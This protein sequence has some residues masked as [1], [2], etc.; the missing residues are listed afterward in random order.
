MKPTTSPWFIAV[1]C[2]LLCAFVIG[3]MI[4]D[5][6]PASSTPASAP[7][8]PTLAAGDENWWMG[9][10]YPGI[11]G[12]PTAS[13]VV[14]LAMTS[15][16]ALY[17]GVQ[18]SSYCED[19]AFRWDSRTWSPFRPNG[20]PFYTN[21]MIVDSEDHIYFSTSGHVKYWDGSTLQTLGGEFYNSIYSLALDSQGNLY[22]GGYF[23]Q[24]GGQPV[25]NNIARWD[26]SAWQP[27]GLGTDGGV[28]SLA[29]DSN[30]NLYA[31]GYFTQAGGDTAYYLARWDGENWW[32]V[33][34]GVSGGYVDELII[35]PAT[36]DLIVGGSFTAPAVGVARWDGASWHAYGT[37]KPNVADL[38][39]DPA[40]NLYAV[41]NNMGAP[42][43]SRW[44]G[45]WTNLA[46]GM[47]GLPS[48]V[49]YQD[50]MLYV[51]GYFTTLA[52]I[53]VYRV[54]R[55]DGS[56]W[57]GLG[58]GTDYQVNALAYNAE[59]DLIAGGNFTN[60]GAV[61]A[62]GAARWD[63][64]LWH[65]LGSGIEGDVNAL[66][67][68]PAGNLIA[69]GLFPTAGGVTMN[70]ISR[71]NGSIWQALG[72]GL[73]GG[74]VYAVAADASNIYAGGSFT[75]AGGAAADYIARWDGAAWQALGSG[76]NSQVR[77]L[78][79]HPL[80]G[81]LYAAGWFSQAGGSPA[82]KVA[83][84]DGVAWQALSSDTINGNVLALAFDPAG[85]LYIGGEF[86][87]AGGVTV[88]RIA[89][90]NGSAWLALGSGAGGA[91]RSLAFSPSGS[92][93]VGGDF[94]TIGGVAASRLAEWDG[95]AWHAF[96]SGVDNSVRALAIDAPG[97][98]FVGGD[99]QNAGGISSRYIAWYAHPFAVSGTVQNSLGDPVPGI[100]ISSFEYS[101]DTNASGV[102]TL[103]LPAWD[104]TLTPSKAYCDLCAFVPISRTVSIT[105]TNWSR[106]DFVIDPIYYA[107][108]GTV[109]DHLGLPT[110]G[111]TVTMGAET[112]LSDADGVYRLRH[113]T[114]GDY[115]LSFAKPD[116][117]FTP[118]TL[119]TTI[120][121]QDVGLPVVS[122]IRPGYQVV[123]G[124]FI[125]PWSGQ[126]TI[127]VLYL[128]PA[129]EIYFANP[130]TD[131]YRW[132]G[133][134]WS[135]YTT[136]LNGEI[137]ALTTCGG[138]LYA[139]GMFTAPSGGGVA[140][141]Y[142]ARW[143]GSAWQPLGSGMN[144][145]VNVLACG[146]DGSLVAG[147]AFTTAGGVT[148]ARVARWDGAAWSAMGSQITQPVTSLAFAPDGT[149]L[150]ADGTIRYWNGAQWNVLGG[151]F[152][153]ILRV[154]LDGSI[155]MVGGSTTSYGYGLHRWDGSQWVQSNMITVPENFVY[156]MQPGTE[157][158]YL[159]GYFSSIDG[160]P[161]SG[162]VFWDGYQ[163]QPVA[164][165]ANLP[166]I[167]K[168]AVAADGTLIAAGGFSSAGGQPISQLAAF[169]ELH[170]IS[171]AVLDELD[172]PMAGVIVSVGNST[173]VTGADGTY[174]LAPQS[175]DC[176]ASANPFAATCIVTAS[177][178]GYIFTP[179]QW[180]VVI[181]DADRSG[182]D[183]SAIPVYTISGTVLDE[184][185]QPVAGVVIT[186]T[187]GVTATTDA[188]GEYVL[189]G[190]PAG[191][192]TL[193][194]SLPGCATCTFV[195]PTRQ[196]T[197]TDANLSGQDFTAILRYTISGQVVD[198]NAQSVAGV[199]ITSS[200]G[201]T[202][203]T[204]LDGHYSLAGLPAG[205]YTITPTLPG[206]A[207]CTFTP[208]ER[209]VTITDADISG[210]DF[211]AVLR[212]AI[213][214]AILD[215]NGQPVAGVSVNAGA[216]LDTTTAADGSYAFAG[217]AAGE[218]TLTPS[219]P[220]CPDCTFTPANRQVN[221]TLADV[222]GQDFSVLFSLVISG[223]VADQYAS[224]LPGVLITL[225]S[226]LTTTTDVNGDYAFT[227][228]TPGDYTIT[229]SWPGCA[230]C[231]F[232]PST[233]EVALD[234]A[235][236]S[237]QDFAGAMHLSISGRVTDETDQ[238]L[239][240]IRII[241]DV[242]GETTTDENGDYR[243]EDVS[244]GVYA[245]IPQLSAFCADC[246]FSPLSRNVNLTNADATG[247]DF[248]AVLRLSISGQIND[249]YGNAAR[250]VLITAGENLT[251]TTDADG[252]FALSGLA[253]GTY[254]VTAALPG[255]ANCFVD[256]SFQVVT[257][258]LAD[259]TLH[260]DAAVSLSISGKVLDEYGAPL[261]GALVSITNAHIG[262]QYFTTNSDGSYWFEQLPPG[263]Y[264]LQV[265][266]QLPP[267]YYSLQVTDTICPGCSFVPGPQMVNLYNADYSQDFHV[268]NPNPLRRIFLPML[269]K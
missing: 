194:P 128:S 28:T 251:T 260:Y 57:S 202:A 62:R 147:G 255:C 49:L 82:S 58:G 106:Q 253:P 134:Q 125:G 205:T 116:Y 141:N 105:Q 223:C 190:L 81:D 238:P 24:I 38:T 222:S 161:A 26:G 142:I 45:S 94:T 1:K 118:A 102:Y 192:Y 104:Y 185:S 60:M 66:A 241:L 40:G 122:D 168:M 91:V 225:S 18:C 208:P 145:T 21:A 115:T 262:T 65:P 110:A 197:I 68:D 198:E 138:F 266:E 51:G 61:F 261:S 213:S 69:G 176:T 268:Y 132:D 259:A 98:L 35:D 246:T 120:T 247:Q 107:I 178:E 7:A 136:H 220:D 19:Q 229:P 159:S 16:G 64:R 50:G 209:Q 227:G 108:S 34:G 22:A 112:V 3:S 182:Q 126:Q 85:N 43:I 264:L 203:T 90:W 100:T 212:F 143:D 157:D 109:I 201:L 88:N 6:Q 180:E 32:P 204:A 140:L 36:D 146:A 27:L 127:E 42:Y 63:G 234:I 210:Q 265:Y 137:K 70:N 46:S 177:A 244:P 155:W 123:T 89:A 83:V 135:L 211:S 179:P 156:D 174:W 86:T 162:L 55:W 37:G 130:V 97:N 74:S 232:T 15:D 254:T 12:L 129:G 114:P 67:L 72:G 53:Y 233:R 33:G 10:G 164:E 175:G 207:A 186:V 133:S 93:V 17:A 189:H 23:S 252:V 153:T 236:A 188:A 148:V 150:S 217:L 154:G 206:C 243:F 9:Y 200:S 56:T 193:T 248:T 151:G 191:T 237:D 131:I 73:P 267:G 239:P 144:D 8:S 92:L 158:V 5:A 71:W 95:S 166:V 79:I 187:E 169:K 235:N 215:Q 139:G 230:A 54:A 258:G 195:P 173:A 263:D 184:T 181:T 172:Q 249:Q 121:V 119:T 13:P 218:Y 170:Y 31:G 39:L 84:W 242:L 269:G 111:V 48:A 165:G 59:G 101:A 256:P 216:G 99:F 113:L 250:G 228:L 214:G 47:N 30:D 14:S 171:G 240:G 78:A 224:P 52:N 20:L 149:L 152:A 44:D 4:L 2:L 167:R 77:A 11:A 257:I 41:G 160:R 124:N 96:G 219:L 245:I 80:S 199:L 25:A 221:L 29:V 231:T 117:I 76:V 163:W 226:G 196:V 75:T 103:T 183:F 87:T